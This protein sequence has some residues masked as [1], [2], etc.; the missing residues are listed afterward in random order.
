MCN[1]LMAALMRA[2]TVFVAVL[3]LTAGAAFGQAANRPANRMAAAVAWDAGRDR[4]VLF[5]GTVPSADEPL[6][7]TWEWDGTQWYLMSPPESPQARMNGGLVYDAAHE[8]VLLHGGFTPQGALDDTWTWDGERWTRM[9]ADG[10]GVRAF[11]AMTYDPQSERVLLFGGIGGDDGKV[12]NDVW[13]WDGSRWDRL[14]EGTTIEGPGPYA[15]TRMRAYR[16]AM[17]SDL[18]NLATAQESY[19]ADN[20]TYAASL[21]ALGDYFT[22]SGGV[23]IRILA[24]SARGWAGVAVHE[25]VPDGK[26]GIYIGDATP[27]FP[28]VRNEGE[29]RCT[30]LPG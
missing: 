5:G 24:A 26:C 14:E 17:R 4:L 18:R 25:Q 13:A 15:I 23:T 19:F 3:L 28:E 21:D 22:T 1:F 10:P 7:D 12:L 2:L 16:A 9:T 6:G 8:R 27:P 11:H 20:V 29:V 30:G